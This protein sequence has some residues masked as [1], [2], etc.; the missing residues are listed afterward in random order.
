MEQSTT[1]DRP[2]ETS[3]PESQVPVVTASSPATVAAPEKKGTTFE[4][5]AVAGFV[6]GIFAMVVAVFAV[7]LAARAVSESGGG[8]G[9]GGAAASSG[10]APST[11]DMD[12]GDFFLDPDATEIAVGGTISLNNVGGVGH[13]LVIEGAASEL[14]DPGATGELVVDGVDPGDYTMYCS[15]PGHREAGMEGTV[16][17]K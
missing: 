6:F 15:V 9:G 17:V 1:A 8:G 4:S 11:L 14:V 7:G 13:D 12:L 2:T 16:T 5:L 10:P 3:A